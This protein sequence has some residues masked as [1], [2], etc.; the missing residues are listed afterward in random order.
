MSIGAMASDKHESVCGCDGDRWRKTQFVEGF[1]PR[2]C[3]ELAMEV[4]LILKIDLRDRRT[5]P[6]TITGLLGEFQCDGKTFYITQTVRGMSLRVA[7]E[8]TE[9][10]A[11]IDLNTVAFAMAALLLE[12]GEEID[13]EASV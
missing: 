1:C 10:E 7:E 2:H 13:A 12:N 9:R 11:A 6:T 3:N 5:V 8:G 4:E